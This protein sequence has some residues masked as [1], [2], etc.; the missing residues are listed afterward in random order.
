MEEKEK[1][2]DILEFIETLS[3]EEL[4]NSFFTNYNY[5][6]LKKKKEILKKNKYSPEIV[7]SFLQENPRSVEEVQLFFSKNYQKFPEEKDLVILSEK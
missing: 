7:K 6:K 3:S 2:I 5:E 4:S 1:I